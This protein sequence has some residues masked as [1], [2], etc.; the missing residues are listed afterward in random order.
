[1]VDE[2]KVAKA[3]ASDAPGDAAATTPKVTLQA[4]QMMRQR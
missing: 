3:L 1:M 2:V 4:L